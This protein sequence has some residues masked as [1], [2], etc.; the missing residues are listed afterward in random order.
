[1][2]NFIRVVEIIESE[3]PGIG[4]RAVLR[5]LRKAAGI[6]TPFIQHYLGP[7]SDTESLV[8]KS[9]L[10]EYISSVLKH[11]VVQ[12]VEEGVVL[13]ADGTTVAL[14]PLLLGLEAGL[15]STSWPRVP[16]L[17]RLSLTK[18][19]VLSFLQYSQ[20][21]PSTSSRLGPDGCW[22]DVTHPQVFTLSG[23]ASL[24]TDALINGGMDGVIL[25]KHI[26]KPNKHLQTLSSLL[27]QYYTHQLDSAGL[28]AAPTLISQL[29]R[30]SFRKLP[31]VNF[32]SLKKHLTR[33]LSIYQ[34]LD[35]YQKKN[36]QK[37]EI[38]EGLKE[39]VH[40]YIGMLLF[41][42]ILFV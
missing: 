7:L 38:D 31:V 14:T 40:S 34:K 4:P 18:N 24:A 42:S 2:N 5:G 25:G 32:A 23:V 28:D 29:R 6:D 13:T 1:M 22:D 3:N 21:E 37:V 41:N 30:S 12:D 15:K 35:Q 17:Y 39:F 16:G 26:A 11:Q 36:K 19:L 10:T 9:T 20:T 33:S 8:L 27:R